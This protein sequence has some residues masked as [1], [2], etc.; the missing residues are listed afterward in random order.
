LLFFGKIYYIIGMAKEKLG[1]TKEK[2]VI[3][4]TPIA[5]DLLKNE[6]K[7]RKERGLTASLLGLASEAI[8]KA[9]GRGGQD[10]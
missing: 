10:A 1:F 9:Y 6:A 5:A 7:S 2:E 4:I 3:G 8:I